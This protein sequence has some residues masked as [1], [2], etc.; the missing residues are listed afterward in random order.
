MIRVDIKFFYML[1]AYGIHEKL[2]S[3]IE[4]VYSG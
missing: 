3:L 2:V 1:K 4:R